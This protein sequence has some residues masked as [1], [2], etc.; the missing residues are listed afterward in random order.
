MASSRT[1]CV[2]VNEVGFF[3]GAEKLLEVWFMLLDSESRQP[4]AGEPVKRGLRI[5]P[6]YIRGE[7][8]WVRNAQ[9]VYI[10]WDRSKLEE[11]LQLVHCQILSHCSSESMD[12]YLLR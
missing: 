5:I 7:T 3:E 6:R 8:G 11:L 9:R 2:S 1:R 12:A 10:F 4:F